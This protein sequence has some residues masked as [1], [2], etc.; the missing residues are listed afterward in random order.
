MKTTN[1]KQVMVGL[2][3]VGWDW[4][5]ALPKDETL[6]ATLCSE[7]RAELVAHEDA[8]L[9]DDDVAWHLAEND[10]LYG[11]VRQYARLTR[12]QRIARQLADSVAS[13]KYL[14]ATG[15]NLVNV[16]TTRICFAA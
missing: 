7:L 12:Q 13:S 5:A 9:V 16:I 1:S 11:T 6:L 15:A 2:T 8:A 10:R 14:R 4:A 3:G